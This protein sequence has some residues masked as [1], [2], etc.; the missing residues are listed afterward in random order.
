MLSNRRISLKTLLAAA[1]AASLLFSAGA[2]AGTG[3]TWET[4]L[5][6]PR[7]PDT[8]GNVVMDRATKGSK[9][10]KPVVFSHWTHRS[11]YTCNR[12]GPT[13]PA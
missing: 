4:D 7:N 6:R 2:V 11:K 5:R 9:E 8:Y 13:L 3:V 10:V 1:F 12:G